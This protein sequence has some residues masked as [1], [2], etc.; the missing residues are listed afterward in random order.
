MN[1][2]DTQKEKPTGS[3]NYPAGHTDTAIFPNLLQRIK[4]RIYRVASWLAMIFRGIA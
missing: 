1:H 2:T 3:A 4:A